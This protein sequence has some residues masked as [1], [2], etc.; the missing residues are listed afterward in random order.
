VAGTGPPRYFVDET[1]F[2]CGHALAVAGA[3]VVHP[4][5]ADLP[6]V[7][8]ST[9]DPAAHGF[10]SQEAAGSFGMPERIDESYRIMI[11]ALHIAFASWS[12]L[13]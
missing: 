5:H 7:P 6:E 11:D 9:D 13:R 2:M 10:V 3:P 1:D 8:R 12:S 4:G